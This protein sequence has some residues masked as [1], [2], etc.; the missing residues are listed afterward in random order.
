MD[1][2]T[3]IAKI[4]KC[5]AL[6]KSGEPHEAAAALRQ[7]QKLMQ[8]FGVEHPELLAA[9]ATEEWTKSCSRRTPPRYE[10]VLVSMVSGAFNSDIIFSRQFNKSRTDIDGGY[11]F[12]GIAP[13]PEAAAYAFTVLRRQLMKARV[14]YIKVA[15]KRYKKN[16]TAAADQFCEGWVIAVRNL[17][18]RVYP[19]ADEAAAINAYTAIH[20]AQT[21]D[22]QPR[23][24]EMGQSDANMMHRINGYV[25]GKNAQLHRGVGASAPA[26]L[27]GS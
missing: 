6:A 1:K 5:M 4:R 3:A 7:A 10:V 23:R 27:L 12:I 18:A 11:S 13:M 2:E 8:Q 19:N 17:V 16:K 24:R 20:Y 26:G 9:G 22:M 14:E 21:T 15:L 25:E